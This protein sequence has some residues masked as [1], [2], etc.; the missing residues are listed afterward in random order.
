MKAIHI[1]VTALCISL[2]LASTENTEANRNKAANRYLAA[3]S[4]KEMMNDMVEQMGKNQP[5]EKQAWIKNVMNNYLDYN[6]LETI[7][8]NSM[9]Q[10]F[11]ADELEA[12][13]D[14]YTSPVGKSAMKKFGTYMAT[15]TPSIQSE[16]LKAIEKS[17]AVEAQPK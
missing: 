15:A 9:I 10:T 13:V 16:V 6:A 8:K 5:P 4:V 17:K 3:F 14:F 11:T 12:I 2:P 1:F 7:M